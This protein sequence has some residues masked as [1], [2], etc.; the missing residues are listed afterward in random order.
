MSCASM[1]EGYY[2]GPKKA[3]HP[4][5]PFNWVGSRPPLLYE[6]YFLHYYDVYGLCWKFGRKPIGIGMSRGQNPNSSGI[7]KCQ[8]LRP[9]CTGLGLGLGSPIWP[10]ESGP[11]V[12][13]L[14]TLHVY[15]L[16]LN[17]QALEYDYTNTYSSWMHYPG[18]MALKKH[19]TLQPHVIELVPGHHYSMKHISYVIMMFVSY[20]RSLGGSR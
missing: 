4:T 20:I 9:K 2:L 11:M 14:D 13:K 10:S 16:A 17:I 12:V 18:R 5:A 1:A 19:Y 7:G 15:M 3:L 8:G 6:A